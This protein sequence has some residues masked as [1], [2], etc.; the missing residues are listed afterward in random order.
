MR[1]KYII[2][3]RDSGPIFACGIRRDFSTGEFMFAGPRSRN[4]YHRM[5]EI[6]LLFEIEERFLYLAWNQNRSYKT[7]KFV[8]RGYMSKE[9]WERGLRMLWDTGYRQERVDCFRRL[10][11]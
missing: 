7:S 2:R 6:I 10:T 4:A 8:L 1:E 3:N 11:R 5:V 9:R